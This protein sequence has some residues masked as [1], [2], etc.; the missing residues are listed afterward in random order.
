MR[1]QGYL[2]SLVAHHPG[3]ALLLQFHYK[4]PATGGEV[5][6]RKKIVAFRQ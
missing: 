1:I 5:T 4:A 3:T 6:I 2:F